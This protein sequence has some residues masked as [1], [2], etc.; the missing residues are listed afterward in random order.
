MSA[1]PA[2]KLLTSGLSERISA[3]SAVRELHLLEKE[4][5]GCFHDV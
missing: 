2:F 3:I 1:D 4:E 5:R